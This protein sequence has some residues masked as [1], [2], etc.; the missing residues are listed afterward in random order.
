LT[1]RPANLRSH[2]FTKILLIKLSAL[3]DVVQTMP[4]LNKLR[5]RYPAAQL[6]WLTTPAMAELLRHNPAISNVIEFSRDEWSA[7]WRP[8]PFLSAARLAAQLRRSHYDL[9]LDLQGQLRSAVFARLSSASVRIGFDRPRAD[10]WTASPRQFPDETRKHAWQGAREGSWLA[11]TDHIAVPSID[12]HAVDRYLNLGAMLGLD[13]GAPDFSFPIPQE[14]HARID[15]LLDYYE[16]A[17]AKVVA[18]APGTIWETKEWR[19]D[20]FAAVARHFRQNGFAVTLIGSERERPVCEAVAAAA[21]GA[22]NLAGETTLSELAALIARAA[23]AVTNDSGPMHL[24]VALGRPV[25]SGFGPTDPVWAGP[26]RRDGAVLRVELPCSPCYL[27]QLSRCMH[28][29][30]CMRQI[31]AAA[32]IERMESVLRERGGDKAPA[33]AQATRRS[34]GVAV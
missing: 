32:V 29:H 4:V 27:R 6:D 28:D 31:S 2:D 34:G 22:I 25:V 26:Y 3:G 20:G 30:D 18:M 23:I 24:A 16:I 14:A 12:V 10:M 19:P 1:S 5:R 15:A 13:D 7:P 21:S 8:A 33:K 17:K 11:Y 9:V